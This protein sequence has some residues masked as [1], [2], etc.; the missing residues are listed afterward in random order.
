MK[1]IL[2]VILV[3]T[4]LS[5][6]IIT[7][8]AEPESESGTS[9]SKMFARAE[10]IVNFE[11]TP[12]QRIYTWN[13]NPYNG[14]MY[15][16]EGETVKGIPYTLFSWELGFDGLLSLEQYKEKASSNYSTQ[17]YCNSVA[18]GRVGPAYGTCCATF[19]SEIFGGNFMNGSNPRYDGVGGIENSSYATCY[20]KVKAVNIQP[21]DAL[22][23]TSGG[24][25]VW[26]A[27]ANEEC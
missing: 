10:E 25:I 19:V 20:K 3:F 13:E 16:E 23:C 24:H 8:Q 14:K 27:E 2:S 5:S 1:K 15:F 18:A 11:W 21:G 12:T 22:S 9:Y 7:A 4:L 26:V 6:F 17:A